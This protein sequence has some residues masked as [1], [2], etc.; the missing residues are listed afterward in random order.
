MCA[1]PIIDFLKREA[2]QLILGIAAIVTG[3]PAKAAELNG[4]FVQVNVNEENAV[5]AANQ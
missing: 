4:H 3:G 5:I 2:I 1:S